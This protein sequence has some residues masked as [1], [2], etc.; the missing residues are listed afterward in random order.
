M[1]TPPATVGQFT[2]PASATVQ[3]AAAQIATSTQ[4]TS[5]T[6]GI[7]PS[8][9]Q[10]TVVSADGGTPPTCTVTFDGTTNVGGIRYLESYVPIAADVAYGVVISGTTWLLGTLAAVVATPAIGI[11]Y[12]YR[13]RAS[14]FAHNSSGNYLDI[15]F[16]TAQRTHQDDDV[17]NPIYTNPY[18]RAPV[19]GV[20]LCSTR[21]TSPAVSATIWGVRFITAGAALVGRVISPITSLDVM[22]LSATMLCN[23]GSQVKVQV[24][25]NSGGTATL[26]ADSSGT[27]QN[28]SF[29]LLATP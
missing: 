7:V 6:A 20:Y 21:I 9:R 13:Q 3:A 27:P 18:F 2:V 25:Q 12:T 29:V 19:A 1:T 24:T 28:A 26:A 17:G 4:S 8:L 11:N 10:C 15:D 22:T 23:A 14:T 16:D 5:E